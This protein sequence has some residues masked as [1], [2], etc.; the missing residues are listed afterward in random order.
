MNKK[1]KTEADPC[2]MT[3]KR[4]DK[5]KEQTKTTDEDRSRFPRDDNKKD[6]G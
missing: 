5:D 2:G 4:T 3:T 6:N 1:R